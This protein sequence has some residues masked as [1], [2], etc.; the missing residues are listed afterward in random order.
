MAALARGGEVFLVEELRECGRL[1]FIAGHG[2]GFYARATADAP[3]RSLVEVL[4]DFPSHF[5]NI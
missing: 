2:T 3:P 4:D 5:G 1:A